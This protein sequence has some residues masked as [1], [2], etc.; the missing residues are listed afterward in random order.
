MR[1][2]AKWPTDVPCSQ[3]PAGRA[4]TLVE[5]LVVISIIAVLI[6]LLLPALA[7]ARQAALSVGCLSNLQQCGLAITM[8]END[9]NDNI[10]QAWCQKA[11]ATAALP[12]FDFYNGTVETGADYLPAN[13]MVWHCPVDPSK[14]GTQG[15]Y[16][17]C[18]DGSN[19]GT[20]LERPY[21]PG[22]YL[23]TTN[24][25]WADFY[26][27]RVPGIVDPT[28]YVFLVDSASENGGNGSQPL[29]PIPP[30]QGGGVF[31]RTEQLWA[32]GQV[33]GVWMAHGDH[34]NALFADG[35]AA[36]LYERPDLYA[37]LSQTMLLTSSG[38]E[39][40]NYCGPSPNHRG[41]FGYW[42][43]QGAAHHW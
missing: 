28:H 9:F 27:I 31:F 5:L 4:F 1:I 22:S 21:Q 12:W 18:T 2:E 15:G 42:D 23:I 11:G 20:N 29:D 26:G 16:A 38:A 39:T 8:Y 41:L 14:S 30:V 35:H 32:G 36:G 3:R 37:N 33:T 6:A 34:A 43:A 7:A 40:S 13:S 17:M 24:P 10:P 19:A 25:Y